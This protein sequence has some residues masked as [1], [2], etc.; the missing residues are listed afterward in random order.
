MKFPWL[1]A[2]SGDSSSYQIARS[3]T[4]GRKDLAAGSLTPEKVLFGCGFPC[5][6]MSSN[7]EA[8]AG[9]S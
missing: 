9:N 1:A 8:A 6:L 7:L 4:K 2:G 3:L 5:K